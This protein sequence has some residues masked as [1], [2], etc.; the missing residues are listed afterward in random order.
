MRK[1]PEYKDLF[2]EYQS[3]E[4]S[5]VSIAQRNDFVSGFKAGAQITMEM[6][7]SIK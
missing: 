4:E 7:K 3:V 6:M 5:V 2:E 1:F